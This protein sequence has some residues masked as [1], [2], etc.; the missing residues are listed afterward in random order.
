MI[1]R[2]LSLSTNYCTL[3]S[4]ETARVSCEHGLSPI[5][6]KLQLP[7]SSKIALTL[8]FGLGIFDI[9]V[10]IGRLV[11]VLQVDEK[12]F[13][14]TEVPA[15]EWLAIEPSIAIII[16]A[17]LCVCRPLLEQLLPNR[18]RQTLASSS[19]SKRDDHIKLVSGKSGTVYTTAGVGI[20]SG[21]GSL[22]TSQPEPEEMQDGAVYVRKDITVSAG[23]KV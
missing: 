20:V 11:T 14:W 23:N 4:E 3:S 9:G 17:C 18:W 7:R 21:A 16:V 8:I 19:R 13:T 10:G 15:L 6:W 22:A 2:I 12:D 5:S 1:S